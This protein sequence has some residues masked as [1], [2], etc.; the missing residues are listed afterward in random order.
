[1][2][3][4]KKWTPL[5]AMTATFGCSIHVALAGTG[6]PSDELEVMLLIIALLVL[7]AILLHGRTILRWM[8]DDEEPGDED[9]SSADLPDD[10]LV[11]PPISQR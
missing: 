4:I 3:R 11:H 9:T 8:M 10:P 6:G 7:T 1:M 5:A 2:N